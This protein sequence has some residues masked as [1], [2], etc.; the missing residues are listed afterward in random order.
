MKFQW[1]GTIALWKVEIEAD[2]DSE[3]QDEASVF[4]REAKRGPTPLRRS[5]RLARRKYRRPDTTS[6]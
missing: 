3:E 2:R 4:L 5:K 1:D 6:S